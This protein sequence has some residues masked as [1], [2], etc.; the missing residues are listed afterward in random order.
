M[1][2]LVPR[3]ALQSGSPAIAYGQAKTYIPPPPG[4]CWGM[5]KSLHRLSVVR[6]F[7]IMGT[8]DFEPSEEAQITN[9]VSPQTYKTCRMCRS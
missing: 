1:V 9:E 4:R 8:Y 2:G 3:L 7:N 6:K 5:L